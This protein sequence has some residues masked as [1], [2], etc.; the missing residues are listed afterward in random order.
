MKL[1]AAI[2]VFMIAAQPVQAGS[3][4]MQSS[5]DPATHGGTQP[6]GTSPIMD[7]GSDHGLDH[8]A[9]DPNAHEC[10]H[11][12]E[13][14]EGNGHSDC[15]NGVFCGSCM[16]GVVAVTAFPEP[17]DAL[18]ASYRPATN[19]GLLFTRHTSPPYRPPIHNS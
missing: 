8:G 9:A 18:N 11:A 3:C 15:A 16:A 6:H 5:G 17:L 10:C 1:L 7:H 4:D 12:G 19:A 2:L 13:T 14:T